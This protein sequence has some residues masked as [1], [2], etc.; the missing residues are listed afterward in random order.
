MQGDEAEPLNVRIARLHFQGFSGMDY[1]RLAISMIEHGFDCP[2]LHTLAWEPTYSSCESRRLFDSVVKE[3]NFEGPDLETGGKTIIRY[4]CKRMELPDVDPLEELEAI[5]KEVLWPTL[6]DI[7]STTWETIEKMFN[8]GSLGEF[9]WD[10]C[11]SLDLE[12]APDW[13]QNAYWKAKRPKIRE[14]A[15]EWCLR[16]P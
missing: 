13:R 1:Q 12:E 11:Q 9:Y 6:T 8:F 15:K 5:G 3:L 14:A 4:R 10:Y 16:N 2:K 7:D